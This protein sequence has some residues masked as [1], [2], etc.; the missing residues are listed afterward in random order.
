MSDREGH[1]GPPPTDDDLSLPKA[2]VAKMISELLP[3]DIVCAKETRDLVIECCVEFIH[4]ISSEAN[5]ICEQESKKT[6]APEH[7]IA[8]LKRLGF[9]AFTHEVEDVLKDH[10]QQQKDREKKVSKF[11][12]SGMT[13]EELLAKQEELFAASRAKYQ[14]T[15]Q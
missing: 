8:A 7:I 4:L 14:S 13:E 1:S 2:T 11:E 9:D 10:K 6:I 3:S 12:Q 15:Q 5:E